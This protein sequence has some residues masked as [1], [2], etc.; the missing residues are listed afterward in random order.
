MVF[1]ALFNLDCNLFGYFKNDS[2]GQA[3]AEL[4]ANLPKVHDVFI[5]ILDLCTIGFFMDQFKGTI[6]DKVK[7]KTYNLINARH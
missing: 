6:A 4:K 3:W 1:C 5:L 2:K 7:G